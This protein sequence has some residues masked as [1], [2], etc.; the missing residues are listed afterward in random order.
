M[1]LSPG[2]N[3][4]FLHVR[5]VFLARMVSGCVTSSLHITPWPETNPAGLWAFMCACWEDGFKETNITGADADMP[6]LAG[7]K[8]HYCCMLVERH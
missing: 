8:V 2:N 4:L 5:P 6:D 3:Q 1:E 7:R